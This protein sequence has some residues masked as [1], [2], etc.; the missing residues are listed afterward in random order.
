MSHLKT[1]P[2]GK[3]KS[4]LYGMGCSGQFYVAA[5]RILEG[6]LGSPHV[7]TDAQLF[8][9]K[10]SRLKTSDQFLSYC[11]KLCIFAQRGHL[12]RRSA[13]TLDTLFRVLTNSQDFLNKKLV[14]QIC[15]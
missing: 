2:T 15:S 7:I 13:I 6:D 1:L 10:T 4:A 8:K 11:M 9:G 5:L 14:D 12:D 3:A